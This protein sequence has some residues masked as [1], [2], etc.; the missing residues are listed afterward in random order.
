MSFEDAFAALQEFE[1][2]ED[3]ANMW[4]VAGRLFI[5]DVL[6]VSPKAAA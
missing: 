4:L 6:R 1:G 5:R 3:L 2:H